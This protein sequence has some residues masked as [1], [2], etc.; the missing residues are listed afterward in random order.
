MNKEEQEAKA[1]R[2]QVYFDKPFQP[3]TPSVPQGMPGELYL[4]SALDYMA[5]QSF[6]TRKALERIADVLEA[7]LKP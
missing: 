2:T 5:A 7:R 3:A 1:A 6:H 4:R